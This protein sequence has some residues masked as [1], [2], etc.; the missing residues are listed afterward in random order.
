M[1]CVKLAA[2]TGAVLVP[3]SFSASR[4][5]ILHSWDKFLIFK[6]FSRVAAVYGKPIEIPRDFDRRGTGK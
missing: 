6:P 5:K 4:K 1:G 2:E 3:F